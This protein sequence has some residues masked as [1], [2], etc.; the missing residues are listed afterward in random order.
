MSEIIRKIKI[1]YCPSIARVVTLGWNQTYKGIVNEEFLQLLIE[2]EELRSKRMIGDFE[3][4]KD[5]FFVLEIDNQVV[6][7]ISYT[8][9]EI[10][11]YKD[12]GEIRAFY[13]ID[14]YKGA[15]YGKKLLQR[16]AR[17]LMSKGFNEIIIGCLDKNPSNSFYVHMGGKKVG[18]QI[19]TKG[20]QDLLENLY[21]YDNIKDLL[22]K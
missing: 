19:I 7:F 11:G 5:E 4:L 22:N 3:T 2:N 16:A 21:H 18:T 13:I 12:I 17:E 9:S 6:G 14:G 8:K 10:E 15:G 1:E 20:N